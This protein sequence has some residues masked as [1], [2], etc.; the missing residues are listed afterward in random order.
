MDPYGEDLAFLAESARRLIARLRSTSQEADPDQSQLCSYLEAVLSAIGDKIRDLEDE[1]KKAPGD[2]EKA[3][4]N[5][6]LRLLNVNVRGFQE[7]SPW[8]RSLRAPGLEL[9]ML[10]FMEEAATVLLRDNFELVIN[11]NDEY[12]YSTVDLAKP[13]SGLLLPWGKTL[14]SGAHPILINYPILERGSLL[15]HPLFVHELG[16][17]CIEKNGL[18]DA[19]YKQYGKLTELNNKFGPAVKDYA[20]AKHQSGNPISEPEAAV[21]LRR[22]L[23]NWLEEV[24]CDLLACCYVGPSFLFAASAFILPVRRDR[25]SPTH[26]PSN[27]RL[28]LDLRAIDDLGWTDVLESKAR[29]VLDWLKAEASRAPSTPPAI[30]LKFLTDALRD[31]YVP[32]LKVVRKQLGPSVYEADDFD[33]VADELREHLDADILPAQIDGDPV[34]RRA[35]LI[36]GW[37]HGLALEDSAKG[38]PNALELSEFQR[39]LTRALEMSYILENWRST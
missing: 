26:P 32:M 6:S 30:Y 15:L 22:L 24:L 2:K 20:K 1:F 23:N 31:L 25:P 11:R 35:L 13:F 14:P 27:V 36:A 33:A 10:Y 5:Q 39:F 37:L 9:G 4:I 21:E 34:D 16:H 28:E 17:D 8:L 38:I 12:M 18:L 29:S 7:V 19:A 3:A